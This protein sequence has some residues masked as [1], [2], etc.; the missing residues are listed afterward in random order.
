MIKLKNLITEIVD[1]RGYFSVEKFG[2]V[3][4]SELKKEFPRFVEI[5]LLSSIDTQREKHKAYFRSD[6]YNS[7][8]MAIFSIDYNDNEYEV[9]ILN[10]FK[11]VPDSELTNKF[12][13]A[14]DD[15]LRKMEYKSLEPKDLNNPNPLMLF[16][17]KVKR[18][19]D[20]ILIPKKPGYA[21]LF[22]DYRTLKETIT[23]VRKAIEKDSGFGGS[24]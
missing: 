19:D 18:Y 20:K 22:D 5:E 23:D 11:K 4:L 14:D 17:C 16:R 13:M 1:G 2:S 15:F 10:T 7:D 8:L 21:I 9:R 12:T 24:S 6:T 3:I